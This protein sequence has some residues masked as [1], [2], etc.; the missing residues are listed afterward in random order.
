MRLNKFSILPL[1]TL[2]LT[3]SLFAQEFPPARV[4]VTL[5]EERLMAPTITVAGTV[6]SLNNSEIATE[7]EGVIT[8][9]GQVGTVVS[10]G[11]VIA[12]LDSRLLDI[13]VTR[14]TAAVKR[15][16][17]DMV[18]REQDV[19]RFQNLAARDNASKARLQEVIA[20]KNMLEQDILDARAQLKRATDDKAR[21]QIRAPFSGTIVTRLANSGEYMNVGETIVRLV[22][23]ENIE[24]A[25]PAPIKITPYLKA[26]ALV[27]AENTSDSRQLPIRT[28]VQVGD[29]VSRM[30]EV[31]LSASET[32]WLVSTPVAI[33]LP[34]AEAVMSVAVPRDAVV[35]R[36]GTMYVYRIN[37]DMT[38]EQVS[39]DLRQAVGLWVPV[40]DGVEA[41]D[42]I[43][44]RG[45]ERLQPGQAV[46]ISEAAN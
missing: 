45:A 41:G 12:T 22:D 38:A 15:L 8:S 2:G 23:T 30:V 24:V 46:S 4:E 11:D 9:I 17:A 27:A 37:D 31:R 32:D 16:E 7:V 35:L 33:N 18:F 34:S 21:A 3:S 26:G 28:V 42:R 36:A 10:K 29:P 40:A 5:A 44:V 19:E 39:V 43:V 25:M 20:R 13:A 1:L 14:A 6:I